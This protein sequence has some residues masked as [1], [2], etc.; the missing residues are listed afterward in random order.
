MTV[1]R[2]LLSALL[3][4]TALPASA[5]AQQPVPP[6]N[7]DNYLDSY[8]LNNGSPII[9]GDVRAIAV[10][11]TNYTLQDDMFVPAGQPAQ[12]GPREPRVCEGYTNPSSYANTVWA[13]F[14]SRDYGTMEI[15]AAS[16]T[17]DEVIRVVPFK[18]LQ[19]AAPILPGGCYD[20]LGG[21]QET[22]RGLVFPKQ[23]YA[24]Q[25]GGVSGTTAPQGGPMQVKFD[26][27]APPTVAA[28]SALFW[29]K[30]PLRVTSLT[31]QGVTKGAKVTLTCT[32][33]ACKK[34]THTARKPAWAKPLSAVGLSTVRMK[35]GSGAGGASTIRPFKAVAHAAKTKFTLMK[36]RRVKKGQTITVRV[37][38]PGFIGRYF[39]WKVKAGAVSNKKISC[40]NPGSTK[41]HKL[42]TC[43]G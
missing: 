12:G 6:P 7:S 38:A 13:A 22:A 23:W 29:S 21:S 28:D 36:N 20:D 8:L 43:H 5:A 34:A 30:P 25:V 19:D 33:G 42:G 39:F 2:A 32:K 41:P 4:I 40:M 16:G 10:D 26:L 15:S 3:V 9:S 18:S 37:T 17:F 1:K 11:T 31:V 27:Q 24:V 14:Q 35:N